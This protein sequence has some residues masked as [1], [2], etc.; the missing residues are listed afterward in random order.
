[1]EKQFN[2]VKASS[3]D[4]MNP[5]SNLEYLES[6]K[7]WLTETPQEKAS[8]LLKFEPKQILKLKIG[9]STFY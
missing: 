4:K 9:S 6:M 1:M 3:E 8:I 2:V 7:R 5:S